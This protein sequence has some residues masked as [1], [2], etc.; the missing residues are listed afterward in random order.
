MEIKVYCPSCRAVLRVPV[1]AAGKVAR[2]PACQTKF[3]IPAERD[4][5]EETVSSWIEQDVEDMQDEVERKL[6]EKAAEDARRK[7]EEERERLAKTAERIEKIIK[8]DG[9]A[10]GPTSTRPVVKPQRTG[11]PMTPGAPVHHRPAAPVQP[12]ASS[13]VATS[14]P[15]RP[16]TPMPAGVEVSSTGAPTPVSSRPDSPIATAT[17]PPIQ[18]P[19][20][21]PVESPPPLTVAPFPEPRDMAPAPPETLAKTALDLLNDMSSYPTNLFV[22]LATP[23]L[24]VDSV[25]QKGV[26]L[27][28]DSSFLENPGFRVSMPIACAFSGARKRSDLMARPFA[29]FDQSQGALRNAQ[30]VEAGHEHRMIDAIVTEDLVTL[31]GRLEKLPPPF[32]LPM[33]YYVGID[34]VHMSIECHTLRREEGGTTCYVLI[35][36]GWYALEWL[37][38]VNGACG[39]EYRLLTHDVALLWSKAWEGVSEVV[40]QRLGTWVGFE[41]GER[42][43]FYVNDAEFGSKDEGLAGVVFTD[44]RMIYH[45]YHR[46]GSVNFCDNPHMVIRPDGDFAG[47]TIRSDAGNIKAARFRLRDL[48]ALISAINA[49]GLRLDVEKM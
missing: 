39:S 33:P 22:D 40:R 35:P 24:V 44:R 5:M 36:N 9:P 19:V 41:P 45:R 18:E 46:H 47:L 38:N 32:N 17:A 16:A 49:S 13:A 37:R 42:F 31:M 43:R 11:M 34:H 20:R 10:S 7:L 28:F 21:V 12:T 26:M 15:P 4:V 23:H 1:T 6:R 29:F 48:D 2:C 8:S 3:L 27:V 14:A 30:E 25:S